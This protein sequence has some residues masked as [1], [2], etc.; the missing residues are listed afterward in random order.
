MAKGPTADTAAVVAKPTCGVIMPISDSATHTAAHWESVRTLLHRAIDRAGMVAH[1]VWEGSATD[2]ITSRILGN[3][4]AHPIA[5]CD[6]SDLNANVMMELGL[7]LASKKP[8]IVVREDG[9]KI[10]FDIADFSVLSYPVD[11]SIL[12]MEVFLDELGAELTAKLD[13]AI[14]GTYRPFLADVQIEILE[15]ESKSVSADEAVRRQLS[16]ISER[17]GKIERQRGGVVTGL[18]IAT[19]IKGPADHI[20]VWVDVQLTEA[21]LTRIRALTG[22]QVAEQ[23]SSGLVVSMM[24]R[25]RGPIVDIISDMAG[26]PPIP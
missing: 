9:A 19:D 24:K 7:R 20:E 2:R 16:E 4:F 14:Q 13:A 18:P 12:R 22:V 15:P 5:I 1:N 23:V 17:L 10:P 11:L 6:I 8:T 21:Q 3:L 26:K 25:F